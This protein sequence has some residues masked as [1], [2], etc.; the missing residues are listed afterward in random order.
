MHTS[1]TLFNERASNFNETVS[2]VEKE[3]DLVLD[4]H[5]SAQISKQTNQT[6]ITSASKPS[7]RGRPRKNDKETPM[8]KLLDQLHKK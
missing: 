1:A 8:N 6:S 2:A 4:V 5:R 3:I 7:N